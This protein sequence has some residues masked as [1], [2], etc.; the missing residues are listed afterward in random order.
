MYQVNFLPWRQQCITRNKRRCFALFILQS[1]LVAI[2]VIYNSSQQQFEQTQWQITKMQLEQ[3]VAQK[4]QQI[5]VINEKQAKLAEWQTHRQHLNRQAQSN[6]TRLNLLYKLP[7]LTPQK[8]WLAKVS[9][10]GN[11]LEIAA[12]S[13]DFHDIS[14]LITRLESNPLLHQVQL[15]KMGKTRQVNYLHV[16][17]HY[18]E[19]TN[20]W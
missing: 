20:E 17:A 16:S 8:S 11:N 12:V 10:T 18:Q 4:Q 3:H 5:K 2:V 6:R 14:Q 13:Y 1:C 7:E 15:I 9:L 19:E